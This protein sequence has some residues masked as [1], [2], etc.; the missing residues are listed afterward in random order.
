MDGTLHSKGY[1]L[2]TAL[3]VVT[4]SGRSGAGF[5]VAGQYSNKIGYNDSDYSDAFYAAEA[6]LE[7]LNSDLSKILQ[8]RLPFGRPAR[9]HSGR[10]LPAKYSTVTF[11]TYSMTGGQ[12]A[13]LYGGVDGCCDNRISR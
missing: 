3:I 6:G 13:R 12:Q 9:H 11:T 2:I 8:E 4:V 5:Y 1:A 7:K 10:E